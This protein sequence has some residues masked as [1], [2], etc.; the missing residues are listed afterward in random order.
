MP[1]PVTRAALASL[2]MMTVPAVNAWAHAVCGDRVF[3]ATLIMDDP[4]MDDEMSLPTI[5]YNPIPAAGGNPAGA[6]TSYGFEWDKTITKSFGFAI[7]DDYI[8][9]RGAG[10]NLHGWDDVTVTLKDELPCSESHEF[11]V[12]VGVIREF[13]GTGSSQLARVGAID[14]VG[15]T[16]PT[17]YAGK[18]LGDLPIGY[19]RPLA[20]TAELGYQISD[21]PRASPDQLAYAASLQ[22]SLPYL[23][24]HVKALDL[25]AFFGRLIPLVE[26]SWTTPRGGPTTGTI[27]PG[28]LYEA[29]AWQLGAEAII[30][31]NAA[32]R[33]SQGTGFIVQFHLFLDDLFPDSIGKPLI[34][35]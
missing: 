17:L 33:Q 29:D 15:N 13:A 25:P 32:T 21:S 20:V 30:P 23:Q 1:F 16:A 3:P 7:N 19:F 18:G 2:L 26:F 12:S 27:A 34:N 14:T 6:M 31:A 8:T 4:G 22:Y 35:D 9:Q 5:Q 24:Q 10:Q 11:M 28:V